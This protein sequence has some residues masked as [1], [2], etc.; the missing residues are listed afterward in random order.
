MTWAKSAFP[1]QYW[2]KPDKLNEEEWS[3]MKLHRPLVIIF[4]QNQ[5]SA[6]QSCYPVLPPREME[7][8]RLPRGIRREAILWLQGSLQL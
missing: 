3:Q 4:F 7:W 6:A 2:I 8:R 5:V 1:M